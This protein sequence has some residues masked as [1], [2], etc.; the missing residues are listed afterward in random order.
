MCG[1]LFEAAYYLIWVDKEQAV[2]RLA[3]RIYLKI[4]RSLFE[5]DSL[6]LHIKSHESEFEFEFEPFFNGSSF[7]PPPQDPTQALSSSWS[8]SSSS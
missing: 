1:L 2:F 6:R 4:E 3:I 8:S 5:E 7:Q